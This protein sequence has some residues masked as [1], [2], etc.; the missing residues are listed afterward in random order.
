[1]AARFFVG[2][3]FTKYVLYQIIKTNAISVLGFI[4]VQRI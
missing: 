3:E 2:I 1:M 4:I